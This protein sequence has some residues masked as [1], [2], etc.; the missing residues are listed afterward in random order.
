MFGSINKIIC[1]ILAVLF[2]IIALV[3]SNNCHLRELGKCQVERIDDQSYGIFPSIDYCAATILIFTQNPSGIATTESQLNK[4]CGFL[5]EAEQCF[6]NFTKKCTTPLQRELISFLTEGSHRLLSEYCTARSQLQRNYLKHAPCLN[7][8]TR[9]PKACVRSLKMALEI[10][11]RLEWDK[12]IPA[13]C[14]AYR[15]FL[16]CTEKLIEQKCGKE[17]IEFFSSLLRMALSRLP[18]IVCTGY[19]V[20]RPEC[21]ILL[22]MPTKI[23]NNSNRQENKFK[24]VLSRLFTA[25]TGF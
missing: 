25:Y 10:V 14:C 1:F 3:A 6:T 19:G 18:D 12:R 23:K 21:G 22:D 24:S 4:Q 7:Q 20:D 17:A 2:A 5:H 13:G 8:V 9:S 15:Q 11:P 16:H